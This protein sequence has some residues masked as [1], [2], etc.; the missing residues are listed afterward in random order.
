MMRLFFTFVMLMIA[1]PA[2]AQEPLDMRHF[3]TLPLQNEGRIQPLESFA[4]AQLKSLSGGASIQDLSALE[5]LAETLFNPQ[6]AAQ[7]PVIDISN[8]AVLQQMELDKRGLY[9]LT[10][11]QARL[12]DTQQ[13]VITLL[14]KDPESLSEDENALI[15]LHDRAAGY[16]KLLRSF[17]GILPL[18]IELPEKYVRRGV[19]PTLEN[20]QSQMPAMRAELKE[21]IRK[22][23][24]AFDTFSPQ[25]Q[26]LAQS[27]FAL[28]KILETDSDLLIPR[29]L[30]E[31]EKIWHAPWQAQ[32][33]ANLRAWKDMISAYRNNNAEL[34]L[35]ASAAALDNTS[36]YADIQRLKTENLYRS[37]QPYF[38]ITCL[39]VLGFIAALKPLRMTA[40]A[41]TAASV[42]AHGAAIFARIYILDRPPVGTLYESLL[43]V[44]LICAAL[45]L[46]IALTRK[47]NFTLLAG[48]FSALLLLAF[49]PFLLQ[50]QDSLEVLVAVLNTNFWLATHVLCITIGYGICII[51]AALAHIALISKAFLGPP[52]LWM[53]LQKSIYKTSMAALLFTTV[54][55]ILGGIWA[56]QS[57]GRFWGWDP[58]ENGALLI[59]LWLIWVQ[60]G[61]LSDH[62]GPVTYTA[63][64]AL[65]SIIVAIAW[66]GVNLLSVG[67][68]SYGFIEGLAGGLIAFCVIEILIIA[69]LTLKI[70][71]VYAT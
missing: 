48:N 36:Q 68:H 61:R 29:L 52:K 62:I 38:W 43:F 35:D 60:H 8:N 71:K 56:D 54:G 26:K 11:L 6:A 19:Q 17:S 51:A 7:R 9:S 41:L 1:T 67:L 30:P 59:V 42:T 10:D 27:L 23:G 46:V 22:K 64:T 55:T 16:G 32:D 4:K 15:A 66:F 45:G 37:L 20:L 24:E 65:L 13:H 34:W 5:W 21:V 49:S 63:L 44:S 3:K 70:K 53:T 18:Q 40:L 69:G 12:R 14:Q 47:D 58:K 33:H 57:W 39:Y 28:D 31:S 50:G 25:E 2:S